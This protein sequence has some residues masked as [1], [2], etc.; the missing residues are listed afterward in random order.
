MKA[1]V[2]RSPKVL[3]FMEVPVPRLAQDNHVLIQVKACGICGSDLRYW[4]GENPWA[5]HTLG[6][7]LDNPPNIILGHEFAGVVAE[8]NSAQYEHLLG[9]RVGVQAY[10]VCG[11]C[12]FCR[13]ARHN[14]C[15]QT[16]HIGHGQGWGEMDFYPGAYAEYCLGWGDLL[17]PLPEQLSFQE[18]AMADIFNVAVHAAGRGKLG[19]GANVLC[20]GG[21][22]VGLSIA[23]VAEAQGARKVFVSETS[24]LARRV[25]GQYDLT[26]IDPNEQS[27]RDVVTEGTA[28]LGVAAVYDSVG[29]DETISQALGLLAESGT[30][31]DLAVRSTP[32]K[33]D[34]AWLASE[35]T[36]TTSSNAFYDDVR[37][38][39][40]L[41]FSGQ[42]RVGPMITHCLPLEEHQ[43]AYDLLLRVPKQA[44]KVVFI[45]G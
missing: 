13:S 16:I 41:I 23:Q 14:L 22:P 25:L 43:Q 15:R 33:L 26:V 10:R 40:E 34:A 42:V 7:H 11:A 6:R 8:V 17:Y 19:Q 32:W 24:P 4:A 30:Y 12:D 9:R 3:E 21:G 1:V 36:I 45:P 37:E 2:L 29:S 27:V 20:I 38:A 28:G 35:R 18:A 44:Y 39:Y 5:L 31:V